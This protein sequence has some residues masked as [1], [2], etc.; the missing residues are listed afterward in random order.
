MLGWAPI[1]QSSFVES[2]YLYRRYVASLRS[3]DR[4]G[5]R[6]QIPDAPTEPRPRERLLSKIRVNTRELAPDSVHG[7]FRNAQPIRPVG[8]DCAW[9][10]DA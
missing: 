10:R 9:G 2:V 6:L 4:V 5:C 3:V 1:S 8:Q 7:R